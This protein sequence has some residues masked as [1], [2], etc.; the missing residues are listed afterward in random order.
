LIA[1]IR[2][3]FRREASLLFEAEAPQFVQ[4]NSAHVQ[5][6]HKPVMERGAA[7]ANTNTE[8]KN[9]AAVNAG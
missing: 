7:L 4:F 6:A 5:I 8:R 3:V 9:S 2:A 1:L